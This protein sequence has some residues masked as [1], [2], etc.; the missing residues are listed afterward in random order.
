MI[1]AFRSAQGPPGPNQNML[2]KQGYLMLGVSG[3]RVRV[4]EVRTAEMSLLFYSLLK[5]D[6]GTH[7]QFPP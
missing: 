7:G 2:A 4:S 3:N 6:L 5:A 1:D